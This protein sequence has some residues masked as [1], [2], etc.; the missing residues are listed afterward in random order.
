SY[1]TFFDSIAGG[2]G[3]RAAKDGIDAIQPHGQNTENSP[4]EE[5]EANYPVRI[6]RYELVA[7]SEGAGRQRGGL[8]LRR[9]YT[10]EGESTFSVLADRAK[11][12]PWGFAGGGP[13]AAAQYVRNPETAPESYPSKFSTRLQ[14]GEVFRVQMG[15]GGGYGDP[16]E[17]DPAQVLEDVLDEKI[18]R[19]RAKNIY[20]VIINPDNTINLNATAS[21]RARGGRVA[22]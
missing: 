11:F 19:E 5:T 7:D 15:G 22:P 10:F 8:G 9:D 6:L 14:P 12:P 16:L 21:E 17:R 1:Y 4:V 2:Y 18:S 3:A 20:G 13:A